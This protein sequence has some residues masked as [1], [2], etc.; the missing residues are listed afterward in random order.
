MNLETAG[1]KLSLRICP[2]SWLLKGYLHAHDGVNR[3]VTKL[4]GRI[5]A[6]QNFT[7]R[8]E[9]RRGTAGVLD[10]PRQLIEAHR[11]K[12]FKANDAQR[13]RSVHALAWTVARIRWR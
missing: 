10:D 3:N 2:G 11:P 12:V 5:G 7:Q 9:A 1:R 6:D 4:G 8:I 13:W